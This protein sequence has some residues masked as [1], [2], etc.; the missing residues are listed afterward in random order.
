MMFQSLQFR[1]N[2]ISLLSGVLI[3]TGLAAA[4]AHII[5]A[6]VTE[7]LHTHAH[8]AANEL[9]GKIQRLRNMGLGFDDIMGFDDACREVV[10]KDR[11]LAFAGIYD[12]HGQLR[13]SSAPIELAWPQS[14]NT[15]EVGKWTS[16][17]DAHFVYAHP[18]H[19]SGDANEGFIVVAVE[20]ALVTSEV[21]HLL[22]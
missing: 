5:A 2:L 7:E 12:V 15:V 10:Q 19:G 18:L 9:A 16:V 11:K 3:A 13:F 4:G 6:Q 20:R 14:R 21:I 22:R 1:I 17:G 8:L